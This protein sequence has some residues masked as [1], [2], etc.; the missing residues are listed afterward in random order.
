VILMLMVLGILSIYQVKQIARNADDIYQHPFTVSNAAHTLNSNLVT[1]NRHLHDV[2]EAK[3]IEDMNKAVSDIS[4]YETEVLKEF[5]IIF[6]RF[7]GEKTQ[8]NNV[9]K[10]FVGWKPIRD[11]IINLVRQGQ[12]EQAVTVNANKGTQYLD[13]LNQDVAALVA[14]AKGK[15]KNFHDHAVKNQQQATMMLSTLA[16]IAVMFSVAIAYYVTRQHILTNKERLH[17]QYL[18]DQNIMMAMLD[19]EAVIIDAS[20]ALCRFLGCLKTDLVGTPSGF[21]DNSDEGKDTCETIMRTI[22]TG[23]EWK[24]E[25]KRIS[26][27]GEIHWASSSILP[28]FDDDYN[29]VGYTNI[30]ADVTSKKL[31]LTDKLTHLYNRRRYEEILPRELRLAIRNETPITLAIIDIDYFKKYN[32]HYGHPQGDQALSKVAEKILESL[33]RPNDYAFRIGGEEFA[34]VFS[35]LNTVESKKFLNEMIQNVEAMKIPHIANDVSDYVTIS[36][37]AQVMYSDRPITE[38]QLYSMADK[39]LYMAKGKRNTVVVNG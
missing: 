23:K 11:E 20:N 8:V 34:V 38:L 7:L 24:G 30:L 37:G 22:S 39:A 29:L 4:H 28:N 9:Y 27:D 13:K 2:I 10:L 12:I 18:V 31:S 1:M 14:F 32:D 26:A 25:I 35:D 3:S 19:K 36:I 16:I 5:D 21:F 15:A 33:K 6:D 17:R